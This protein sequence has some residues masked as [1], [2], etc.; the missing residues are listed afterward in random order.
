MYII[1]KDGMYLMGYQP[2]GL[3]E[4]D[5]DGIPHEVY[6]CVWGTNKYDAQVFDDL[7]STKGLLKMIDGQVIE[8]V[9][10]E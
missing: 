2:S 7:A 8:V 4:Y 9:M 5:K 1:K 6:T 3:T 10:K